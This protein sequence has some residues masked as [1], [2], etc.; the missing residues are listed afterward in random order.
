MADD[1]F[2]VRRDIAQK[3]FYF[4]LGLIVALIAIAILVNPEQA[5]MFNAVMPIL[6]IAVPCLVANIGIYMKLVS[7]HDKF[8]REQD[9]GN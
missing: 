3:S 6:V 7:D 5:P 2:K 1:P 4:L 8:Q 9:N